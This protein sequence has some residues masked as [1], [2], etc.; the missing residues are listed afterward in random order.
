MIQSFWKML[1]ATVTEWVDDKAPTYA[2]SLAYY[3]A[4]SIA[5]TL[6]IVVAI[7]GSIFGTD[8]ARSEIEAQIRG[9]VGE[10]GAR[11]LAEM[12][13]HASKWESGTLATLIG[14]VVLVFG[15]TG[16]FAELQTA[17]NAIWNATPPKINGVWAFFRTRFLSFAMVLGIGFLLLVSLV[18]SAGLAAFGRWAGAYAG[19]WMSVWQTVNLL[20]GFGV[21]TVLIAMIYKILPDVQVRWRDVWLGA[22]VTTLLFNVGKLAIGVYLGKTAL[23]SSYGAAGSLAALLVWVYYSA[24]IL[25]FGAEF[26]QIYAR[27]HGSWAARQ[28]LK[29][30][31]SAEQQPPVGVPG[32][33]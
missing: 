9:P 15:A 27:E 4:F 18:L 1:K 23:V 26:T 8:A 2:A 22:V 11:A 13:A 12:V 7:A 25:L 20:M 5:P 21:T 29:P 3:T 10:Q 24:M 28:P 33:F 19:A 30:A 31:A 14:V 17:L 16:V 6:V 32:P